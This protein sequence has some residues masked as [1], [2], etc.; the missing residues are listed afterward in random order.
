MWQAAELTYDAVEY[1]GIKFP[2]FN[3]TIYEWNPV[4]FG[5][6]TGPEAFMPIE[7]LGTKMAD[8]A[9]VD[10]NRCVTKF[11]QVSYV[12]GLATD[13]W[14]AYWIES[15]SNGTEG[16]FTKREEKSTAEPSSSHEKRSA[17]TFPL[18]ELEALKKGFAK[19]FNYSRDDGMY[20]SLP[21]PFAKKTSTSLASDPPVNLT[22]VDGGTIG[23]TNP[24]WPLVQPARHTDF[25]IVWDNDEEAA[26]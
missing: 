12:L 20:Q 4:E 6:W 1:F 13:A 22:I 25:I 2:S 7:Y 26:P 16:A 17:I 3:E 18:S 5:A 9:P 15:L 14:N 21:N 10:K 24:V 23:Q 8:G 19:A 11:E